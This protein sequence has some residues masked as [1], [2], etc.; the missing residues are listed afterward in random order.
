MLVTTHSRR[1]FSTAALR[2]QHPVGN[3]GPTLDGCVSFS[4][5]VAHN[6]T[7]VGMENGHSRV[8]ELTGRCG[9]ASAAVAAVAVHSGGVMAGVVRAASSRASGDAPSLPTPSPGAAAGG[10]LTAPAHRPPPPGRAGAYG[11]R[12]PSQPAPSAG[13]CRC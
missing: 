8:A 1:V 7:Q 3:V 6:Y 10:R 12:G 11:A 2:Y 4:L 5:R 13:G 9:S